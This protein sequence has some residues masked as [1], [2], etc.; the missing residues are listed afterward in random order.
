LPPEGGLLSRPLGVIGVPTSAGAFAPGQEQA[1]RALREAGLLDRLRNSGVDARDHGDC[2]SWRWRPDR[3][4]RR[5]QHAQNVVEI[6]RDT[7]RRVGESISTGEMTLVL[8][9]DC[10]VGVGTVAGHVA[11]GDR[12]GLLYFDMHADLNVPDS[13]VDGALDWMGMAHMLGEPGAISELAGAG[14]RVPMLEAEQVLVFGWEHDQATEFERK[15][16]ERRKIA[17]VSAEEIA[18][19]PEGAAARSGELLAARCE[20]MLVHFDVDVIDFT[21]MPLSENTGRNRGLPYE[22]AMRALGV[23]LRGPRVAALTITELNPGHAE[24]DGIARFA[25]DLVERLAQSLSG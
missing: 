23:L 17:V 20:R 6:V 9:G 13:V 7:A 4:H 12:V 3:E 1:P 11:V 21:D 22:A 19:D 5:A 16:M 15:I 18:P 14:P 8:G 24:T 2:E 10:T 25:A